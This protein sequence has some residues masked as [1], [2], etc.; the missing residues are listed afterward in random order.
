[1]QALGDVQE[2]I[3]K[4]ILTFRCDV[5]YLSSTI[6]EPGLRHKAR[7]VSGV[8]PQV[9]DVHHAGHRDEGRLGES[10]SN[11]SG[12]KGLQVHGAQQVQTG[13]L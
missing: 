3:L 10:I 4:S 9:A 2:N 7:L 12:V 5:R 11:M 1:M 13:K 6:N 8:R